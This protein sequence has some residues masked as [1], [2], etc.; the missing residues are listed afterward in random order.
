MH[1][2]G[3]TWDHPRGYRALQVAAA[4]QTERENG[5][6][7]DWDTHSLEG[8][9]THPIA[10]L[11]ARYDLVVLDHPHVGE[12]VEAGCLIPLET[13]FDA[14][15]IA[16]W[17]AAS[18]GPSLASYRY[19]E[20]HWALPL[21]AATQVMAARDDLLDD[22]LPQTW[23]EVLA[24]SER[25][26]VA[27][28]LAGPHAALTFQ[29]IVA[30]IDDARPRDPDHFVHD[31]SGAAALDIMAPLA[32][33]TPDAA[34]DLNPIAL[35]ERMRRDDGVA[36][37]PLVYGYVNYAAPVDGG[38]AILFG[39]A[40]AAHAGGRRGSTLGGTGIGIS[41]RA[42]ATPALFDH[43]RWLLSDIAQ[44][45]FIPVH[46]GQPSRRSAWSE[47]AVN[48]R[49]GNFYRNTAVTLEDAYV[50]PRFPNAIALQTEVSALLRDGLA[51]GTPHATLLNA[52]QD[53]YRRHRPLAAEL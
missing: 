15:E 45:G 49:W 38:R 19:A 29:S 28:S 23:A 42:T 20:R 5:L 43:L 40:P 24:L 36:L 8:F 31:D 30:A 51:S 39:N 52:M 48:A 13:L 6:T 46:D 32:S 22:P 27:L 21:D 7:L 9:E 47:E 12:A 4:Q 37:C 11:C 41:A 18:I 2:R 34:R 17:G 44:R 1:Y 35:L 26:P 53:A 10:D 16:E 25:R 33:R 50:R 14:A 3:L